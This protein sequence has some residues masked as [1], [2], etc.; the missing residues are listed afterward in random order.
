MSD[1]LFTEDM[2][3]EA[4]RLTQ[5]FTSSYHAGLS[6]R[7][8][9]PDV[10]RAAL[11]RLMQAPLPKTAEPLA[12]LFAELEAVIVENS[13][14]TAHPRFL[15][16]VQP[17]PNAL[18]AY[19]EHVAAVL[20]QNC[21]LWHLSPAAHA[22]EQTVLRWFAGLYGFPEAGG[23][24]ITSGGSAANLIALTAARDRSL[25]VHARTKGLQGQT[26]PL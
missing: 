18:S 16:Y 23:G 7:P 20:N 8:V 3:A 19:A 24:I 26:A 22:I 21:N 11:L 4:A 1:L 10:D 15:P 9:F 14:H 13:T 6:E 2:H 12:D 17:S 25:G 5:S